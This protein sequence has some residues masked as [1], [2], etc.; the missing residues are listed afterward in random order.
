[1]E[2]PVPDLSQ[3]FAREL[4]TLRR[5]QDRYVLD[6]AILPDEITDDEHVLPV[7][8]ERELGIRGKLLRNRA[9]GQRC[10]ALDFDDLGLRCG[11]KSASHAA[12][13]SSQLT[14]LHSTLG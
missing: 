14:T 12:D 10:V 1:M 13:V 2:A 3:R 9:D 6:A 11:R 5:L 7:P 4:L 8:P